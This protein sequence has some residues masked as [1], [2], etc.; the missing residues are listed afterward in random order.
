LEALVTQHDKTPTRAKVTKMT[1]PVTM[2]VV[3]KHVKETKGT[4]VYGT[5]D[6]GAFVSQVYVRK[7]ALAGAAPDAVTLS[8]SYGA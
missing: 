8:I 5:D 6:D 2:S 4:H 1:Q 7:D 3:L